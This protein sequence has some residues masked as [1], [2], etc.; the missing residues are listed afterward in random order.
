MIKR[1]ILA[2]FGNV[3]KEF[4]KLID[5]KRLYI[6]EKYDLD[7]ILCG[8]L[9]KEG[10]IF[11]DGGIDTSYLINCPLGSQGVLKYTEHYKESYYNY[12]VLEGDILI[13][14][15]QSNVK[16]GGPSINY[17]IN[18]IN[19]GMDIVMLSKGALATNFNQ[20]M[21]LAGKKDVKIKYSGA[22]AAALPTMDL[23]VYS[24]AGAKI[25]SITGVLNGTTNY[26]L[27]RMFEENISFEQ[28]L[29]EAV[30]KGIAERENS[31]DIDGIDS[32][33]KIL[34]LANSL[35][36][37]NYSLEDVVIKGIRDISKEDIL[38]A[39]NENKVI[40]LLCKAYY[41][42]EK[43]V[44][45]VSPEKVHAN[46]LLGSINGSNKGVVFNTDT[47]GEIYLIGGASNPRGAAAAALKDVINL[48]RK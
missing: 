10:C 32:A 15:T 14:C 30:E 42:D 2:G 4:V 8:V 31:M 41:K 27:N 35:M 24:L 25:I 18:S 37:S 34:L 26:I 48:C 45:E 17:I 39:K 23:G 33:S 47:M 19:R 36:N 43:L 16:T 29:K 6:R 20:L 9:E 46:S 38:E 13:E 7:L 44:L 3:G 21:E 11:E 22:T 12:P 5:E 1:V 28:A 40:K